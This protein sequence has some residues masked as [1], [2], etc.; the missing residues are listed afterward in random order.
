[1]VVEEEEGEGGDGPS[2]AGPVMSYSAEPT[3]Y[4]VEAAS[5]HT[6]TTARAAAT[7]LQDDRMMLVGGCF[8]LWL[9]VSIALA[10]QA[11]STRQ[12]RQRERTATEESQH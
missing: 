5:E 4:E 3:W 7:L 11:R 12:Q 10:V 1:V 2:A 6:I 9:E 8:V